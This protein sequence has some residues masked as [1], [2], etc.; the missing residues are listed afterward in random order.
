M[1]TTANHASLSSCG[2]PPSPSRV[3]RFK[4]KK[5]KLEKLRR[6]WLVADPAELNR[7]APLAA[8]SQGALQN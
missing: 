8:G 3:Q 1:W 2:S 4:T 7:P 5:V 6:S